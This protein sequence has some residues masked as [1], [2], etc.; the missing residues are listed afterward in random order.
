MNSTVIRDIQG[1]MLASFH[2]PFCM[3][4]ASCLEH[5]CYHFRSLILDNSNIFVC[6]SFWKFIAET[7]KK[8]DILDVIAVLME[9]TAGV[10]SVRHT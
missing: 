3:P 8:D 6:M 5:K 7:G 4:I 10:L 9:K 2:A 1:M